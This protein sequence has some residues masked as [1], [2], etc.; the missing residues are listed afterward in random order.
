MPRTPEAAALPGVIDEVAAIR[1]I[2]GKVTLLEGAD[3]TSARVR[4]AMPQ[5]SVAHF[6][7]HGLSDWED[8][9]SSGLLL[10][11]HLPTPFTVPVISQLHLW[12][13]RLAYLS[14]CSTSDQPIQL[15]DEALHIT[16]AFQ[17]AG[18]P[19]VI[20]SLWP[21]LDSA[22]SALCAMVYSGLRDIN[23]G[24]IDPD[25][26]PWALHEALRTLREG[27]QDAPTEW[28]AYVHVGA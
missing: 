7:C 25:R 23:T 2:A 6:A 4:N 27:H 19:Q 14:A 20:G 17:L 15:A 1:R 18:Y 16:G 26:A 11:D 5:H 3:A 21:V 22:N 13:N 24:N 28:A 8:P 12:G 9:D 10:H